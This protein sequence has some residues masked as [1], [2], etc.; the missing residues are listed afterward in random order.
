MYFLKAVR[1][2]SGFRTSLDKLGRLPARNEC[3]TVCHCD[4]QSQSGL[5]VP[6]FKYWLPRHA[7]APPFPSTLLPVSNLNP[8]WTPSPYLKPQCHLELCI[9]A[10]QACAAQH[11]AM[12]AVSRL[13]SMTTNRPLCTIR[14]AATA[15][16]PCAGSRQSPSNFS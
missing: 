4:V 10:L 7:P 1:G 2:G 5:G 11:A 12:A 8:S 3:D 15:T 16:S 14:E 9:G 6:A 13:F